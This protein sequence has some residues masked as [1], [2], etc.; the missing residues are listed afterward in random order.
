MLLIS[1][2]LSTNLQTPMLLVEVFNRIY[3]IS[4]LSFP[5]QLFVDS[6]EFQIKEFASIFY[7]IINL[8]YIIFC[9]NFERIEMSR[10]LL[11]FPRVFAISKNQCCVDYGFFF[12]SLP[13]GTCLRPCQFLVV[14]YLFKE[15]ND[16]GV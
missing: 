13:Q 11:L 16:D 10:L 7:L 2:D 8:L 4:I 9:C 15:M 5:K 1:L 14:C 12:L 6:Y 3:K